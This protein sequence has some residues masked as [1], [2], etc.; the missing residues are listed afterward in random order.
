MHNK[1]LRHRIASEAARLLYEQDE[2][3]LPRAKRKAARSLGLR[4]RPLDLP[5]NRE[6][7]DEFAKLTETLAA[8]SVAIEARRLRL[9]ALR[10]MRELRA[11]APLFVGP[12]LAGRAATVAPIDLLLFTDELARI[13][14]RLPALRR[15][16]QARALQLAGAADGGPGSAPINGAAAGQVR[17]GVPITLI[18][19][20]SLRLTVLPTSMTLTR[21]V[22]LHENAIANPLS[23]SEME[24]W[25][26]ADRSGDELDAEIEGLDPTTDR[27]EVY[28]LLLTQLEEVRQDARYHPEGDALHHSLQVFDLALADRPYDEEFLTAALLHDVGKAAHTDDHAA[29]GA[30][31]LDGV[32][33]HR[34]RWL[35]ANHGLVRPYRDGLLAA[36]PRRQLEASADFD[37]LLLL[38][39]LDDAGRRH[40]APTSSLDDAL[41]QL[42]ELDS[43]Q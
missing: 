28:R 33:T 38:G 14:E 42:R 35:V 19:V 4:F 25:L 20:P 12:E 16:W 5:S 17:F 34:A 11:F 36:G 21:H 39:Q 29:A 22:G 43:I 37:D 8:D 13:E 30:A 10:V 9:E 18:G 27:F 26:S 23:L 32:V 31:L 24:Q 1:R 6:V 40:G 2:D 15:S 3:E 41:A 7:R